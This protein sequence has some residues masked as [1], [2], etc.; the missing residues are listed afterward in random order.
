[1][2][3]SNF[4]KNTGILII[5][6]VLLLTIFISLPSNQGT[7]EMSNTWYVLANGSNDFTGGYGKSWGKP[8]ATIEYAISIASNDDTI[9]VGDGLFYESLNVNKKLNI[10]GNG[11]SLTTIEDITPYTETAFYISVNSV[12]ISGFFIKNFNRAILIDK[13]IYNTISNNYI[14]KCSTGIF[15]NCSFLYNIIT[16]NDIVDTGQGVLIYDS[17]NNY[18]SKNNISRC[19]EEA[20]IVISTNYFG[21]SWKNTI[22][23][24]NIS[25]SAGGI[26]IQDSIDNIIKNNNISN[27]KAPLTYPNYYGFGIFLFNSSKIN[28][29]GNII[30]KN[31][32]GIELN[33]GLMSFGE[34]NDNIISNNILLNNF[35]GINLGYSNNNSIS[36]NI[37][38]NN[39]G[40]IM[41]YSPS[42]NNT[43]SN[44]IFLNNT[45]SIK[46]FSPSR[47]NTIIENTILKSG[48]NAI[49]LTYSSDNN[50]I[51]KNNLDNANQRAL[52]C[53]KNLESYNYNSIVY[54]SCGINL[55]SS[56]GNNISYNK[57]S[58]FNL[59]GIII[60]KDSSNNIIFCNNISNNEQYGVTI[61]KNCIGNHIYH[62][63][64]F[65][66]A[67]NARDTST[68]YWDDGFPSAGNYWTDYTGEDKSPRDNIGD[69]PYLIPGGNN[70]DNYP[71]MNA[72]DYQADL[73]CSDCLDNGM[74]FHDITPG[75]KVTGAFCVTNYGCHCSE[76]LDWEITGYPSWGTTW[77]FNPPYGYGLKT[78]YTPWG[79]LV[80][81]TF[82]APS[83]KNK[84]FTGFVEVCNMRNSADCCSMPVYLTTN[85]NTPP[86]WK[87]EIDGT[88]NGK[89]T[90]EYTYTGSAIDPDGDQLYYLWDWGDSTNSSWLG[91]YPSGE[92]TTANHTWGEEGTY[93]IKAKAKDI[94]GAESDWSTLTVRVPKNRLFINVLLDRLVMK[95]PLIQKILQ[96]ILYID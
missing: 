39:T 93:T 31:K 96:S 56:N 83:D 44:N 68:N 63:C 47:N 18:I 85:D 41:F 30:K 42:N 20:I 22:N 48:Y 86:D 4:L 43:I 2:K 7:K 35:D 3:D 94:K 29:S 49:Y 19:I 84:G 81:A 76:G 95:F 16:G 34:S 55:E 89:P 79:I 9:F 6:L 15:I 24:N 65:Y 60:Q 64:F 23:N 53:H 58:N 91:P 69:S 71:L 80:Y 25:D 51:I 59:H 92:T 27:N 54:N 38:Q 66:N 28:I 70:K 21:Y 52:Q 8:F 32:W 57:I 62:N 33:R 88:T 90:I 5:V 46:S 12:L 45:N 87:D 50:K 67:Q 40:G 74:V 75:T 26:R 72:L 13:S 73:S 78:S 36:S 37:F 61:S 11:S 77:T 17:S 82:T 10:I 14:K 1:M